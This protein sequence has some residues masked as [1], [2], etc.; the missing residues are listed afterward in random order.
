MKYFYINKETIAKLHRRKRGIRTAQAGLVM[1][2]NDRGAIDADGAELLNDA[3]KE[4]EAACAL[5]DQTIQTMSIEG[6]KAHE[7]NG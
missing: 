3:I 4:L 2:M 5:I 1:L 6:A 7:R